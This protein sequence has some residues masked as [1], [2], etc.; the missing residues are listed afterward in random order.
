MEQSKPLTIKEVTSHFESW[1]ITRTG[2]TRIPAHLWQE[3][4]SLYPLHRISEITTVLRLGYSDFKKK[5]SQVNQ[6]M[7]PNDF[8]R[9]HNI[10]NEVDHPIS[11]QHEDYQATTIEL[12]K[13]DGSRIRI[14]R[15]LSGQ[16]ILSIV[17]CYFGNASCCS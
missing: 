11:H 3:A 12:E 1:R 16:A 17:N 2:R 6:S 15:E 4:V 14:Q 13:G 9:I 10:Q 5:L 8:I 7:T